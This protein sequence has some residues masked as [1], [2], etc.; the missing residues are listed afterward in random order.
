MH[1]E[2]FLNKLQIDS[3]S[4][5]VRYGYGRLGLPEVVQALNLACHGSFAFQFRATHVHLSCL[6]GP[7]YS[8]E[9]KNINPQP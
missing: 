8:P 5:D 7:L 1:C 4:Y 2:G 3:S 9:L 6:Q